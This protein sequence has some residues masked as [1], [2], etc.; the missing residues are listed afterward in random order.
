MCPAAKVE[1][2]LGRDPITFIFTNGYH[3]Y[4]YPKTRHTRE[5]RHQERAVRHTLIHPISINVYGLI[6]ICGSI[7]T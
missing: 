5:T 4:P 7:H 2:P 6:V 3:P 1:K